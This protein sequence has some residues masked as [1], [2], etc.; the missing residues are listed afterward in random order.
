MSYIGSKEEERA[1]FLQKFAQACE[2]YQRAHGSRIRKQVRSV[3]GH[4][5]TLAQRTAL[6]K[7]QPDWQTIGDSIPSLLAG[8]G[9]L[10]ATSPAYNWWC[11]S[12]KKDGVV[13]SNMYRV[14]KDTSEHG[15]GR[16]GLAQSHRST[17]WNRQQI[18]QSPGQSGRERT[19]DME[20]SDEYLTSGT[21][22]KGLT[23][24][25]GTDGTEDTQYYWALRAFVAELDQKFVSSGGVHRRVVVVHKRH[26]AMLPPLGFEHAGV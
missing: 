25:D 17:S 19:V 10:A 26:V 2:E 21:S 3:S 14:L 20:V 11:E 12:Y 24:T 1:L 13:A 22:K 16:G 15:P 7:S 6:K 9:T 18:G 5:M 4:D 23:G 8:D